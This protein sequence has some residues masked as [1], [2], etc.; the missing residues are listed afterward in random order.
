MDEVI[1]KANEDNENAN[2]MIDIVAG[3]L[4]T[5]ILRPRVIFNNGYDITQNNK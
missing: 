4:P 5:F 3:M 1:I 2:V